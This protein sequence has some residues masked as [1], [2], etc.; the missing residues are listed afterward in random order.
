[1]SEPG[2]HV[3]TDLLA[4]TVRIPDHVVFRPFARETVVL[5]LED[6][7]LSRAQPTAGAMLT[8]LER[9]ATVAEAAA[10]IAAQYERPLDEIERDLRELCLDLHERGLI[11]LRSPTVAAPCSGIRMPTADRTARRTDGRRPSSPT[12]GRAFGVELEAGFLIPELPEGR[13]GPGIPLTRLVPAAPRGAPAGVAAPRDGQARAPHVPGRKPD[14]GRRTSRGRGLLRLGPPP[15]P[16]FD[17]PD[18]SRVRSAL[19]RIAS[20][21][22]ERLLFAQVLPLASALRGRELFHASAVALDGGASRSSG[23]PAPG[24]SSVAAHLVSRGA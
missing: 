21:R 3:E 6:R 13:H 9:R 17:Q 1:M 12:Y 8:E 22:W 11:E 20:W 19:P 5:N 2:G 15:R 10:R 18:G 24:K 23:C 14:D 16:P 7:P 4:A